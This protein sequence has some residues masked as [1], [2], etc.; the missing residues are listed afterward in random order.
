LLKQV[1]IN[2]IKNGVKA[3]PNG[4]KVNVR[5]NRVNDSVVIKIIDEGF[6][7]PEG[8]IQKLGEPFYSTKEKGTGLGLMVSYRIIE[9]HKGTI[10]IKSEKGK[11]TTIQIMLPMSKD[12]ILD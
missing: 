2:L 7:I 10:K 8:V 5:M 4:G 3:T 12:R 9:E 11:G 1:F 6:G